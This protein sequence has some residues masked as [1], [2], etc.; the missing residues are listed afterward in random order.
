MSLIMTA[1]GWKQLTP[2]AFVS[3][4]HVPTMLEAMGIDQDYD[5]VAAFADY[6]NSP[7]R[8]VF[9]EYHKDGTRSKREIPEV[10]D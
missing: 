9:F 2:K 7:G 6:C 10:V 1:E 4:I 3:P 8:G 5:G